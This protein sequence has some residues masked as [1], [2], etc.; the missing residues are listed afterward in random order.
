MNEIVLSPE[1]YEALKN[2]ILS[3]IKL[4]NSKKWKKELIGVERKY[5]KQ[6]VSINGGST[7]NLIQRVTAYKMGC[8]YAR[9]IP[10]ERVPEA[11]EIAEKLCI[12]VIEAFAK[13]E[14]EKA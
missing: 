7:W 9:E 10:D 11:A 3:D 1:Q 5:H 13:K 2:Q 4:E 14:N 12:E 8:K 6:L